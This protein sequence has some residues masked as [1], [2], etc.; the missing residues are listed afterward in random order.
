MSMNKLPSDID[1]IFITQTRWDGVPSTSYSIAVELARTHR[2]FF[3]DKPYTWKD[4]L[5]ITKDRGIRTRSKT[6]F[7]G[8]DRYR[9]VAGLSEKFRAVV[10][11]LVL[12]TNWLPPGP[13][14]RFFLNRNRA[15]MQSLLNKLIRDEGIRRYVVF[16]S[17]NP[18]YP[19]DLKLHPKP[20]VSIYQCVDNMAASHYL[21]KHGPYL[22]REVVQKADML[23][24]TSKDII[25][26]FEKLGYRF[27]YLPNAA[28][29]ELFSK[30]YFDKT[31]KPSELKSM[32]RPIIGY[33]GG[34][35]SRTDYDLIV[36]LSQRNPD[37]MIVMIGPK[38]KVDDDKGIAGL[39]NVLLIPFKKLH[40]LPVY[41]KY[42]DC[43][44][45]PFVY[46]DFTRAVYPL[47]VNEY[48]ASGRP[49]V[50]TRFS[51]DIAAFESIAF[52]CDDHETFV[53]SVEKAIKENTKEKEL[54]RI[55]YAKNNSWLARAEELKSM[56]VKYLSAKGRL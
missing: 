22:E 38:V 33:L 55:E 26:T 53:A 17:F 9:S 12:P 19:L 47:K 45:I 16:N 15:R 41:A 1:F 18:F 4:I 25:K 43:A 10:S 20:V 27:E 37:K 49:V 14:Y 21:R 6:Y 23:L 8:K 7:L 44:I 29:V 56:I 32:N 42:F 24:A 36:K 5:L 13:L 2:V 51:E 3:I 31:E 40:E 39:P 34:I 52:V 50:T 28:N 11:Y 46:N 30:A 48:L 35:D 54:A